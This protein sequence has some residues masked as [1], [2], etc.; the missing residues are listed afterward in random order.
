MTQRKRTTAPSSWRAAQGDRSSGRPIDHISL[1]AAVSLLIS[2]GRRVFDFD[3]VFFGILIDGR[4]STWAMRSACV[5]YVYFTVRVG[6]NST[7]LYFRCIHFNF[8]HFR[9]SERSTVYNTSLEFHVS[10]STFVYPDMT[11]EWLQNGHSRTG[12][13]ECRK[14]GF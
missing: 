6:I 13:N 9:Q 7:V 11:R 12:M 2:V 5:M 10:Y 3:F 14:G 4:Q 1:R 8:R